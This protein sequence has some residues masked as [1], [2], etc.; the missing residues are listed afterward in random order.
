MIV[1][2]VCSFAR[3]EGREQAKA[4]EFSTSKA[5]ADSQA[6]PHHRQYSIMATTMENGHTNKISA[7]H[8][9]PKVSLMTLLPA[10]ER[11]D[12][13][14]A[15]MPKEPLYLTAKFWKRFSVF[16]TVGL[17]IASLVLSAI[18]SLRS[19]SAAQTRGAFPTIPI[20]QYS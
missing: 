5:R 7:A 16:V 15:D 8:Q 13:I 3:K 9:A 17:S 10:K 12:S 20:L 1:D 6:E 19:H 18:A 2:I 11:E 4:P 14:D